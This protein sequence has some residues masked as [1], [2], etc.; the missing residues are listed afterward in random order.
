MIGKV[1]P[2]NIATGSTIAAIMGHSKYQTPYEA[3]MN[4]VNGR[5]EWEQ[6]L[7][8]KIGD[9]MEEFVL[10]ESAEVIGLS[11]IDLDHPEPYFLDHMNADGAEQILAVSLDGMAEGTGITLYDNSEK[12]IYIISADDSITLDGPGVLEAKTTRA[13][14]VDVPPLYRGPLQL[15]AQMLCTGAQWGAVCTLYQGS[16]L[17]IYVYKAN[18]EM[19]QLIINTAKDFKRRV[20]E[21]DPYPAISA[22]EAAEKYPAGE[23]KKII[24]ADTPLKEKIAQLAHI[25]AELKA[26]EKLSEDLQVDIMESMQDADE[27]VAGHYKVVWPVRNI[28]AKPEQTKTIPAVEAQRVRGKTLQIKEL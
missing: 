2:D 10:T 27:C 12:G 1:T 19:Q 7:P 23:V 11:S 18:P 24:D 16:E 28:K 8:A 22:S 5:P 9:F 4:A 21:L 25:R 13:A 15:Q 6:N 26:Y 14:P 17:R 20:K 3:Y